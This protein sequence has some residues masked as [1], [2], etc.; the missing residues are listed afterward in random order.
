M[1]TSAK[2]LF[3][4]IAGLFLAA[5]IA[6]FA[7]MRVTPFDAGNVLYLLIIAFSVAAYAIFNWRDETNQSRA[8]TTVNNAYAQARRRS[9]LFE[10]ALIAALPPL[11]AQA[12]HQQ[13]D[14][15]VMN[16]LISLTPE[17]RLYLG[18][19]V[20]ALWDVK[21]MGKLQPLAFAAFCDGDVAK[22]HEIMKQYEKGG[23]QYSA[24]STLLQVLEAEA[25]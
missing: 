6:I 5:L 15:F 22:L 19:S 25:A 7:A 17:E 16:A 14:R 1:E 13:N 23:V 3:K 8:L 10:Q 11:M 12:V 2:P 24:A 18:K 20:L 4:L 21:F 9:D